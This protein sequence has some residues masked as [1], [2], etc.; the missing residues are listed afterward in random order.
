MSLFTLGDEPERRDVFA[1][2]VPGLLSF[3]AYN[4]F[5]GEVKGIKD[6]QAEYE[7]RFGPGDYVPPVKWTYW[8][9]R[10]M[11]GAGMADAAARGL[12]ARRRAAR[13]ASSGAG[14]LLALLVPAIALPY[15]ANSTGWI[16]TEIGRAPWIVFGVM[17][18]ESGVSPGVSAGEVLF[19]L[20]GFT[21]LYAALM[22]ADLYLLAKFAK[23]GLHPP[24]PDAGR[25]ARARRGR[26]GASLREETPWTSTRSGSCSSPCCSPAS[27]CSRASTTASAI[28]LPFVAKTDS[29]RRRVINTIGPVWDGNEVW[30]LTA[31]GAIFAAFPHWYATLFSGFYLALFLILVALIVRGRGL[32]VP[33]QGR[34]PRLARH[35]GLGDLRRQPAAGAAVGRGRSPTS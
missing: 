18:I 15:L 34:K 20:V 21:L 3:L 6:L 7:A 23:A 4:R 9:F 30:I 31:G 35:L 10:A 2:K 1:V 28:L 5:S 17:R 22:V 19:T 26:R 11:V 13:P 16:F 33:Q 27:S 29:E 12:G 32:R 8:T 25:R 14:S 24:A